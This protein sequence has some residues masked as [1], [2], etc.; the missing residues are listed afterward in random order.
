MID[1]IDIAADFDDDVLPVG[2]AVRDDDDEVLTDPDEILQYVDT[3]FP[4]PSMAYDTAGAAAVVCR[5]VFSRFS[6]FVKDVS[7]SAGPLLY[8]L[9][10]LDAHLSASQQSFRYLNGGERPDHLDCI[11]LPKLQHIRVT[12][13]AVKDFEIPPDL[14]GLWRYL[15]T[16]YADPVFRRTCPSDQEIVHHW[17]SK[18][19]CHRLPKSKQL[20]Y[21]PEGVLRYSMDVPAEIGQPDG[22]R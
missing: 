11:V 8:E 6:Y 15:A 14:H 1:G 13:R 21:S 4:V 18:P 22:R 5:D 20:F 12:A 19:E 2:S 9:R 17:Q 10:R 7:G 16:A 3:L